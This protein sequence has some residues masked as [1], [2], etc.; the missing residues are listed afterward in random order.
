MRMGSNRLCAVGRKRMSVEDNKAAVRRFTQALDSNDLSILPEICTPACA[1]T[2]SQGINSDP[3]SD[4]HVDLKQLV[5]PK[6]C[7]RRWVVPRPA[8]D[9]G[10]Y[11]AQAT[12]PWERNAQ[13]RR[14]SYRANLSITCSRSCDIPRSAGVRPDLPRWQAR[15]L[16]SAKERWLRVGTASSNRSDLRSSTGSPSA[17]G[18]SN[19]R[20]SSAR[21][22]TS[23]GTTTV[24][25]SLWV[26]LIGCLVVA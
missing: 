21:S 16:H 24:L 18:A 26:T 22:T 7:A 12:C 1:D 6:P 3:W 17:E 25:T 10:S 19:H 14:R 13:C 20:M 23:K 8:G 15:R 5:G 4:H 11:S 9:H 2:W